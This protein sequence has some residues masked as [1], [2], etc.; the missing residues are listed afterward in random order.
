[1]KKQIRRAMICT[2]AMM[3]MGIVSLTGVTYAW[4][5]TSNTAQVEGIELGIVSREGGVL[6]S[7]IPNP[8]EWVYKLDLEINET[9]FNPASMVP[10]NLKS[11][12]TI[13]FYNGVI[14]DLAP[15][16]IY[17][18]E[19]GPTEHY[20]ARDLYFYND[21]PDAAIT[22]KLDK[23]YTQLGDP[24][25]NV[26]RAMRMA[27]VAHGTY[28]QATETKDT[29]ADN[30]FAKNPEDVTIYEFNPFSHRDGSTN[31]KT[32][33][34]VKAASGENGWFTV[35]DEE[36]NATDNT[37]ETVANYLAPTTTIYRVGDGSTDEGGNISI[38]IPANS[39]YRITVYI[40]LEGQD[41]DCQ[42]EISGSSMDIQLGF[43]KG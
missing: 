22:V 23:S 38:E 39:C 10:E 16:Q 7:S 36:K 37:T 3:L 41:V 32:T 35:A 9:N 42:N 18:E 29:I 20:I 19:I 14:N 28:D 11:D 40:W 5:T 33:C 26:D 25:K 31:L 15:S 43:T 8:T 34:G 12:G 1:M 13:Q 6:M 4:F 17:T 2:V 24:T 30:C 27:I 21:N